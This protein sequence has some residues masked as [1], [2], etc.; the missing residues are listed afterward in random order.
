MDAMAKVAIGRSDLRVSRLGFGGVP[1]GGL[2][3]DRIGG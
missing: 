3:Q 1:L 2:Y